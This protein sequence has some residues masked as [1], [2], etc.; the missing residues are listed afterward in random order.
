MAAPLVDV[1]PGWV[2]VEF[3]PD[4]EQPDHPLSDS[5]LI[6][7]FADYP[8]ADLEDPEAVLAVRVA[9]NDD[10]VPIDRAHWRFTDERTV[11][12][13]G[14]FQAF[15]WYTLTYR[16]KLCPVTGTGL[17]AVRDAVSHL[18]RE[19]GFSH[20]FGYGVSQ[21]GRLLRQFLYEARNLDEQ[22]ERGLRRGLR[23]HRRAGG[24]ASST[25]VTPNPRS[26]TSSASPTCRPTTP[27]GC[28]RTSARQ[29]ASPSC[30]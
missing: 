13:D 25:T 9:P 7:T 19:G 17:L 12:L 30:C 14:G 4:A 16:T 27:P 3:K 21:S 22:G 10:P 1:G 5:M 20:A 8:T 15:H 29:A 23:A 6:F 26:P 28:W 24:A 18:R 2:R 11:A